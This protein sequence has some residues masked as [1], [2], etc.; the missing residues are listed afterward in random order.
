MTRHR[1]RLFWFVLFPVCVISLG[2]FP[3]NAWTKNKKKNVPAIE[4]TREELGLRLAKHAIE[5]TGGT[6]SLAG[7]SSPQIAQIARGSYLVNGVAAC[8]DCHTSSAGYLA[9]GRQFRLG[10]TD[11]QGASTIFSRNLTPDPET[12]LDLTEEEFIETFRTGR[13]FHDSTAERPNRLLVMPW[14]FYRFQSLADLKDMY[15]FLTFIPAVKNTLRKS[16]IVPFPSSP[17]PY[18]DELGDGD[19]VSDPLNSERGLQIPQFFSS[20]PQAIVFLNQFKAL[21]TQLGQEERAKAG[22]GSY[23]VNALGR[24]SACHTDGNGD[25]KFDTGFIPQTIDLNT[26]NYLAGGVNVGAFT[27]LE[28]L[29]SRNLTPDSDTG[30][31]L[32]EHEFVSVLRFGADFQRPNGSLRLAPHFPVEFHH[33]RDDLAAMY[34]YLRTIPPVTNEVEIRD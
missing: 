12:G 17:I 5:K 16:F 7:L 10:V 13:D 34:T 31:D 22:R 18:P 11:I 9:G 2:G 28:F 23:L 4:P 32:T 29:A 15:A 20:G 21:V 26:T 6:F 27:G 25:G 3:D 30:L 1:R 33:T 24:C 14:E 19:V 8:G